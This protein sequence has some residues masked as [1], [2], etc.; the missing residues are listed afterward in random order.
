MQEH[1]ISQGR[2][3]LPMPNQG[4]VAMEALHEA[5]NLRRVRNFLSNHTGAIGSIKLADTGVAESYEI[6]CTCVS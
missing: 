4:R 3:V 5:L 1:S 6:S 2:H